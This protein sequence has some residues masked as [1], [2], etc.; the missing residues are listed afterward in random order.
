VP[1]GPIASRQSFGRAI[2]PPTTSGML[3]CRSSRTSHI[4]RPVNSKRSFSHD[5]T[6]LQS[7]TP[8]FPDA[9][10]H[11]VMC[12]SVST[13]Q[14]SRPI[15]DRLVQSSSSACGEADPHATPGTGLADD[16]NSQVLDGQVSSV[17]YIHPRNLS[18]SAYINVPQSVETPGI[19]AHSINASPKLIPAEEIHTTCCPDSADSTTDAHAMFVGMD[20]LKLELH[21]QLKQVK[22]QFEKRLAELKTTLHANVQLATT[23]AG[24]VDTLSDHLS[25]LSTAYK[26]KLENVDIH[27]MMEIVEKTQKDVLQLSEEIAVQRTWI[28]DWKEG[29]LLPVS[30]DTI[31][32]AF[33]KYSQHH[34]DGNHSEDQSL[35]NKANSLQAGR[36]KSS[37]EH[38][39]LKGDASG[40]LQQECQGIQINHVCTEMIDTDTCQLETCKSQDAARG[41]SKKLQ[42]TIKRVENAF[43][44]ASGI[45][46]REKLDINT[47]EMDTTVWADMRTPQLMQPHQQHAQNHHQ[48][49]AQHE[50]QS[51]ALP[52]TQSEYLPQQ[53]QP[54]Q[55]QQAA[56][57]AV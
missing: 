9:Q 26:E 33:K 53:Q 14:L 50:A 47:T 4:I 16:C 45:V 32:E 28:H 21:D 42:Q 12:R 29:R 34:A 22:A 39:A 30:T 6:V 20:K 15:A 27:F 5:K 23:T 44:K 48:S 24:V 18:S 40:H 8:P 37:N 35:K 54:Q 2:S 36:T 17:P 57:A 7:R 11:V 1:R 46:C 31:K 51:E 3:D 49:E 10:Q 25:H 43:D 38:L 13:T 41:M 56:A 19:L 52:S 55:Q